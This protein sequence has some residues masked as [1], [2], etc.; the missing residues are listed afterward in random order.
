M[1]IAC[2]KSSPLTIKCISASDGL[3]LLLTKMTPILLPVSVASISVESL[4]VV[5]GGFNSARQIF[6]YDVLRYGLL[7]LPSWFDEWLI[8]AV[9]L[10]GKIQL[11]PRLRFA[12][13][14]SA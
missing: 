1:S 8:G 3:S 5:V 7:E 4:L 9:L 6:P 13:S 2:I 12:R 14:G 10:I 11:K